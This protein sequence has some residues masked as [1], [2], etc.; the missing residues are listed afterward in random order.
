MVG[1]PTMKRDTKLIRSVLQALADHPDASMQEA[2]LMKHA[3]L[4]V[5]VP[6]EPGAFG[7]HLQLCVDAGFIASDP[8]PGSSRQYWRLTWAGHEA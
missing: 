6:N 4:M 3:G 8:V 2:D 1:W 5:L 7:Y